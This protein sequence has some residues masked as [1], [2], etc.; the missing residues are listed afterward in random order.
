MKKIKS[1]SSV[2]GLQF[3][4]IW[5]RFKGSYCVDLCKLNTDG[6]SSNFE[7]IVI[8]DPWITSWFMA[9]SGKGQSY[10]MKKIT[11]RVEEYWN[12]DEN[13]N[14]K[15]HFYYWFHRI[16]AELYNKKIKFKY[17]FGN[18]EAAGGAFCT[19]NNPVEQKMLKRCWE[20]LNNT[21]EILSLSQV[22]PFESNIEEA[23]KNLG[24]PY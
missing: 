10:M 8:I 16:V 15:N 14:D 24:E 7:K 20:N 17:L 6:G 19:K 2:H 21:E 5:G 11:Q 9:V 1:I 22:P 18:Q 12:A 3:S 4:L 13:N 23:K